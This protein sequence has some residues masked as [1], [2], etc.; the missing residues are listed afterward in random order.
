MAVIQTKKSGPFGGWGGLATAVGTLTG[1]PW[2]SAIGSGMNAVDSMYGGDSE[3][4]QGSLDK[5]LD[6]LKEAGWINPA[7]G[8]IAKSGSTGA[9]NAQ[10]LKTLGEAMGGGW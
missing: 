10:F 5:M 7:A 2:L 3:K 1:Q 4:S 8:S 6:Y 9:Q